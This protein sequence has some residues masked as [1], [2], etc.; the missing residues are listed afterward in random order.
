MALLIKIITSEGIHGF[1][2]VGDSYYM[3]ISLTIQNMGQ[4][5]LSQLIRDPKLSKVTFLK[6][7]FGVKIWV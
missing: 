2:Q 5:P 7:G 3:V 6:C 1:S 4:T